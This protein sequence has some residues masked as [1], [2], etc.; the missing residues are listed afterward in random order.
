MG[1]VSFLGA[2]L[3]RF[4]QNQQVKA[5]TEFGQRFVVIQENHVKHLRY[6]VGH[7]GRHGWMKPFALCLDHSCSVREEEIAAFHR[8]LRHRTGKGSDNRFSSRSQRVW[9]P[10]GIQRVA[11]SVRHQDL[12]TSKVGTT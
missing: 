9:N 2:L 4:V 11:E 10:L 1:Q 7:F 3:L 12:R 5:R 6:L 8:P